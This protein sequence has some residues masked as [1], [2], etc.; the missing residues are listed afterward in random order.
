MGF[1]RGRQDVR[2]SLPEAVG[3]LRVPRRSAEASRPLRGAIPDAGVGGE[4]GA[5]SCFQC[6]ARRVLACAKVE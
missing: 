3:L 2:A 5:A 6:L 1:G 4:G